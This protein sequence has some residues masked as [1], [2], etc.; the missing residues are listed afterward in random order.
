MKP[1]NNNN[2][3][4]NNGGKPYKPRRS[5]KKKQAINKQF[6]EA[7]ASIK[8]NAGFTATDGPVGKL[9]KNFMMPEHSHAIP[10]IVPT[11]VGIK[12]YRG[13]VNVPVADKQNNTAFVVKP[14]PEQMLSIHINVDAVELEPWVAPVPLKSGTAGTITLDA[15]MTPLDGSPPIK[16]ATAVGIPGQHYS[17]SQGQ[18]VDGFK[19][20][21]G[22]FVMSQNYWVLTLGKAPTGGDIGKVITFSID[23]VNLTNNKF[24]LQNITSDEIT[25]V[26]GQSSYPIV[27]SNIAVGGS[28]GVAFSLILQESLAATFSSLNIQ[29]TQNYNRT[30]GRSWQTWSLWDIIGIKYKTPKEQHYN[31]DKYVITGLNCLLKN[32]TAELYKSG[33]INAARFPGGH[34]VPDFLPSIESEISSYNGGPKYSAGDLTKGMDWFFT[35]EKLEDLQF[36]KKPGDIADD[37][38]MLAY[39]RWS[40]TADTLPTFTMYFWVNIEYLS[41]DPS[42]TYMTSPSVFGLYEGFVSALVGVDPFTENPEHLKHIARQV[43]K[44]LTSPQI[45]SVARFAISTGVKLAP[46]VLALI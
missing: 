45:K 44:V 43:K 3:N 30:A 22:A 27:P 35:P 34:Q 23:A 31:A 32:A 37:P 14:D 10:R 26:D 7:A 12:N 6:K 16:A 29:Y 18:I 19:Y 38:Y 8:Q 5:N 20:F 11:K 1:A 36:N 4:Q 9:V 40:D 33:S 24:T 28:A 21:T 42:M 13:M 39:M 25:L 46:L 2:N 41:T 17:K 15:D